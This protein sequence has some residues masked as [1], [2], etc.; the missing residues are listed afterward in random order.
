VTCDGERMRDQPDY[1]SYLVRLWR[2]SAGGATTWRASVECPHTGEQ[3]GFAGVQD[4]FDFL[5]DQTG[6]ERGRPAG[7]SPGRGRREGI[8]E[9]VADHAEKG[10]D[11]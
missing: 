10:G 5:S 9:D 4:L 11:E 8:V 2:V 7:V 6:R 1:L 3:L